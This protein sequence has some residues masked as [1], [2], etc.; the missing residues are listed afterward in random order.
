MQA[1]GIVLTAVHA[2]SRQTSTAHH[3]F[4]W[5]VLAGDLLPHV[6]SPPG[7]P[8]TRHG[9]LPSPRVRVFCQH[10]IGQC[11]IAKA[12]GSAPCRV[13]TVGCGFCSSQQGRQAVAASSTSSIS[14]T[15]GC[16]P[17][18]RGGSASANGLPCVDRA[19]PDPRPLLA[20]M[21]PHSEHCADCR[22]ALNSPQPTVVPYFEPFTALLL[23][24]L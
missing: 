12:A 16:P 6:T 23:V 21:S 11:G 9:N 8:G 1:E 14:V 4:P 24:A 5:Q 3:A 20:T 2:T 19:L 18:A 10:T 13:S 22:L 17:G 15:F 7:A